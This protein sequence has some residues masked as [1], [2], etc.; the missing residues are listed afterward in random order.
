MERDIFGRPVQGWKR[1][2]ET[3]VEELDPQSGSHVD[4]DIAVAIKIVGA[5]ALKLLALKFRLTAM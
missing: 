2:P 5:M 1:G 4:D 3:T